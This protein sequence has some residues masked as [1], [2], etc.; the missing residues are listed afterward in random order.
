MLTV[1][2]IVKQSK[3]QVPVMSIAPVPIHT[4]L[5]RIITVS[6]RAKKKAECEA[7]LVSNSHMVKYRNA[8]LP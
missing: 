7:K 2:I 3:E 4:Q 6:G 1:R 8:H 5:Y